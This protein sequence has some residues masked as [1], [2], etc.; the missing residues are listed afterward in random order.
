MQ[1]PKV[2]TSRHL[3]LSSYE[4]DAFCSVSLCRGDCV[5]LTRRSISNT[6]FHEHRSPPLKICN[7]RPAEA[8]RPQLQQ[9]TE[10]SRDNTRAS[11]HLTQPNAMSLLDMLDMFTTL[12]IGCPQGDQC[13]KWSCDQLHPPTRRPRCPKADKCYDKRC[14][15][16]QLHPR[17][18]PCA[19]GHAC[20]R[21]GAGCPF[22]HGQIPDHSWT[23][24]AGLAQY[25]FTA[26]LQRQGFNVMQQGPRP[27]APPQP[28]RRQ[29]QLPRTPQQQQQQQQPGT[30]RWR[31]QQHQAPQLQSRVPGGSHWQPRRS[32]KKIP[33]QRECPICLEQSSVLVDVGGCGHRVC[34]GCLWRQCT[35]VAAQDLAMYP[36]RCSIDSCGARYREAALKRYSILRSDDEWRRFQRFTTLATA[37]DEP[38]LR[39]VHCPDCDVP[40]LVQSADRSWLSVPCNNA[41]CAR[42]SFD[43]APIANDEPSTF[44]LLQNSAV[45]PEGWQ[46]CPGCAKVITKE[47]GCPQMQCVCGH[48]FQWSGS[49]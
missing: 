12:G 49:R 23:T 47:G 42:R 43:A 39:A 6:S 7:Q 20:S 25:D 19:Y 14:Q 34:V 3:L 45:A 24:A 1:S 48:Q 37:R 13:G 11:R 2:Q 33:K 18:K 41:T 30:Q 4:Q 21:A 15:S 17:G 26:E 31:Q 38:T 28:R 36:L 10:Q 5:V 44:A 16:S 40:E 46:R 22:V 27:K 8:S 29:Q 32:H 35:V 9:A